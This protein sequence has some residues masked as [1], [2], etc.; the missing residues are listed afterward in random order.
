MP[1]HLSYSGYGIARLQN[2]DIATHT[3]QNTDENAGHDFYAS[4]LYYYQRALTAYQH[5]PLIE[6]L[7]SIFIKI[8]SNVYVLPC[9]RLT[10]QCT[11]VET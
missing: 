5:Y 10:I 4:V 7:I 3:P 8:K 1:A 2:D 11:G 6:L 9:K